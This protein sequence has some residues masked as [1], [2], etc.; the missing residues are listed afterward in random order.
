MN[1]KPNTSK[2]RRMTH[3]KPQADPFGEVKKLYA[4]GYNVPQICA[5]TGHIFS[6]SEINKALGL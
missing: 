3:P 2:P 5:K 6:E 1:P 4:L